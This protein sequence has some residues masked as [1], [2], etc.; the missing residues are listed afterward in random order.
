M[1]YRRLDSSNGSPATRFHASA[2]IV[3]YNIDVT[4]RYVTELVVHK[5]PP[6]YRTVSYGM[7][8]SKDLSNTVHTNEH[9]QG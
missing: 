7:H 8:V 2:R 5:T 4:T 3:K 1:S 9:E 6:K